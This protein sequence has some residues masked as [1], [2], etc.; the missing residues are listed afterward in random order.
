[1]PSERDRVSE[2]PYEPPK[3]AKTSRQYRGPFLLLATAWTILVIGMSTV[4]IESQI[5]YEVIGVSMDV[6]GPD[7]HAE[8]GTATIPILAF[9]VGF[10]VLVIG[11]VALWFVLRFRWRGQ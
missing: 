7:I 5:H 6:P 10:A 2:N 3:A 11:W 4:L 1:M 9:A 8:F